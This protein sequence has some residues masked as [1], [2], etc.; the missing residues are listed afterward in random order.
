[1]KKLILILVLIYSAGI[2]FGQEISETKI[3]AQ[4]NVYL[5]LLGSGLFYT[6]NYERTFSGPFYIRMGA[7]YT[8]NLDE[9]LDEIWTVP[10]SVGHLIT[11]GSDTHIE[12][13][14][15]N[16]FLWNDNEMRILPGPII[17]LRKQ[18][19]GKGGTLTRIAFTPLFERDGGL[20]IYPYGGLSFGVSF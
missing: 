9:F 14:I 7:G 10:L 16:T 4:N 18:I 8:F 20:N 12:L 3:E 5:E 11:I 19:F 1:M 15:A 17:G 2:C 13:A 6:V